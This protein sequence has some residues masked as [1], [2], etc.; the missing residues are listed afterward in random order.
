MLKQ[1]NLYQTKV[2]YMCIIRFSFYIRWDETK[3]GVTYFSWIGA[4]SFYYVSSSSR[5][6]LFSL[7][8]IRKYLVHVAKFCFPFSAV[9]K[10]FV[11]SFQSRSS[12]N[13]LKMCFQLNP[14]IINAPSFP[15]VI[16]FDKSSMVL[17]TGIIFFLVNVFNSF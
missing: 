15:Y 3:S 10:A 1:C 11:L 12:W 2:W 14:G 17:L 8:N 5:S 6:L 4:H 13:F 16:K 9:K 7:Q